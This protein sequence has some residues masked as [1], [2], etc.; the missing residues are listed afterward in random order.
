MVRGLKNAFSFFL[1]LSYTTIRPLFDKKSQKQDKL[2]Y[3]V[4]E[5]YF[6]CFFNASHSVKNFYQKHIRL[7]GFR[8]QINLFL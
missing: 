4:S 3:A 8:L 6:C 5:R 2:N 7:E 1:H